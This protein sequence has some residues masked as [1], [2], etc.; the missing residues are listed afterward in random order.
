MIYFSLHLYLEFNSL[1]Q[2]NG[3]NND[4]NSFYLPSENKVK[5]F[6]YFLLFLRYPEEEVES[7][8]IMLMMF[9]CEPCPRSPPA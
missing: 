4:N 6:Y 8:H 2:G 7:I 1:C 5:S 9:Q 3:K